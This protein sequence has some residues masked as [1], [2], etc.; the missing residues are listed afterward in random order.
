ML[1]DGRV[2]IVGRRRARGAQRLDFRREVALVVEGPEAIAE[3]DELFHSR[4]D[5]RRE[6]GTRRGRRRGRHSVLKTQGGPG[7]RGSGRSAR[8]VDGAG[9]QGLIPPPP[10]AAVRELVPDRPPRGRQVRLHTI[11]RCASAARCGSI[12]P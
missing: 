9:A 6:R 5:G 4:G 2:A 3:I 12:S 1:I 10:P 8:T 7:R 11:P